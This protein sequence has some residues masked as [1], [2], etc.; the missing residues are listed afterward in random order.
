MTHARESRLGGRSQAAKVAFLGAESS[1]QAAAPDGTDTRPR[2][3]GCGHVLT[4]PRS[5]ARAFGPVCWLRTARGQLDARRDAA[6]RS[7]GRLAR[8]V[9]RLDVAGLA[10]VAAALDDTEDALDHIAGGAR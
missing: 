5:V 6:G 2:C 1:I 3:A 4:A 10:L 8:R 7:L 9:A